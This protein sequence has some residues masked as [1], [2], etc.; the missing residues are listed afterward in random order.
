[1]MQ[2]YFLKSGRCLWCE[3][4]KELYSNNLCIECAKS[5]RGKLCK[6]C[7]RPFWTTH[8]NF[9]HIDILNGEIFC[10]LCYFD[11]SKKEQP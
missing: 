6:V 3:K 11:E 2:H 9:D 4:E 7:R 10:S 8:P 1:M 5:L